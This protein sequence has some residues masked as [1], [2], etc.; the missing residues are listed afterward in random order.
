MIPVEN[1]IETLTEELSTT[2]S[3]NKY[4]FINGQ[5]IIQHL[6]LEDDDILEFKTCW[7][8]LRQDMYMADGGMYRF[9]RYGQFIK[10]KNLAELSLLPHESYTQ[11][12]S[13]NYLNGGIQ[14]HFEPLTQT[15]TDSPILQALLCFMSRVYD[16]TLGKSC[17]WNIRLHPYRISASS[18][19]AGEPTPEGLH[20]DG[21]T[22]ISSIM[23]QKDNVYGGTTTI[24]D[25]IGKTIVSINL[26]CPLDMM[27]ADDKAI[28]HKVSSITPYI[29]DKFAHRDV[30]VI[31]FTLMEE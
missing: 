1:N 20:R 9:R 25:D 2:L 28:M 16:D 23:I 10:H 27:I 21:V 11:P 31:A 17:N 30:L 26:D 8:D 24:T 14:R 15:F 7:D 22:F 13:V 4:V 19:S 5:K 18:K 12:A 6:K 3:R 29:I